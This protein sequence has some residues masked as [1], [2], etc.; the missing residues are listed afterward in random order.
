MISYGVCIGIVMLLCVVL[1]AGSLD[2]TRWTG[3]AKLGGIATL[4][5]IVCCFLLLLPLRKSN[6]TF[7]LPEAEWRL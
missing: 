6:R 3:S 1:S 7:S 4:S 5:H 2:L